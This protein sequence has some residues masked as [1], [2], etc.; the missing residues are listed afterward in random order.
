[1]QNINIANPDLI[2]VQ[3]IISLDKFTLTI[4]KLYGGS[5]IDRNN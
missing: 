3:E 1:M 2:V 4:Q 5:K